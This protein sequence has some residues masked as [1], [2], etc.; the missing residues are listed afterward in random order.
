MA[1]LLDIVAGGGLGKFSCAINNPSVTF[2]VIQGG[3]FGRGFLSAGFAKFATL[4]LAAAGVFKVENKK[5]FGSVMK[6]TTVAAIVGGTASKLGGGKFANGAQT[7]AMAHFLNAEL[8]GGGKQL[9]QRSDCPGDCT[10]V[11]NPDGSKMYV[12]SGVAG[13]VVA[14]NKRGINLAQ[15]TK[16]QGKEAVALIVDA[17]SVIAPQLR[18]VKWASG[19]IDIY[20]AVDQ[21][22]VKPLAGRI[23]GGSVKALLKANTNLSDTNLD[24][25]ANAAD[26]LVDQALK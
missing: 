6:R 19:V 14:T 4:K 26:I 22:S 17:G 16:T 18:I 11:T 7:A 12:P 21:G 15:E 13:D 23:A 9:N 2:L 1:V 5:D 10:L 8:G 25:A 3:K 20:D 24:R